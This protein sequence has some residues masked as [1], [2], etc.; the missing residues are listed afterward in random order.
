MTPTDHGKRSNLIKQAFDGFRNHVSS[1]KAAFFQK[2]GMEFIM[3]RREG[4]YLWDIDGSKRL[5][6]LRCNG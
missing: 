4:P 6:N 1:G 5:F 2:Y 3:G